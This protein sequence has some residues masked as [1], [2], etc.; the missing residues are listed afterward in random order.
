MRGRGVRTL[1]AV[2]IVAVQVVAV[3]PFVAHEAQALVQAQGA[4]VGDLGLE[5]SLVAPS[6]AHRSHR[7]LH[8]LPTHSTLTHAIVHRKHCDV[9][10][11]CAAPVPILLAHN[12]AQHA[13]CDIGLGRIGSRFGRIFGWRKRQEA[14]I[15]PI[16]DEITVSED[17]VWL[18]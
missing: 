2:G 1:E 3:K 9:P 4:Q 18:R 16:V 13:R 11:D 15:W 5:H 6:I 14:Q 12:S 7:E 17:R 10:A 8:E